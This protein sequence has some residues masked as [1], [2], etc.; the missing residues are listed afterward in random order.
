MLLRI[1]GL[2][3]LTK[4]NFR[5]SKFK[6]TFLIFTEASHCNSHIHKV[7]H[8][9]ENILAMKKPQSSIPSCKIINALQPTVNHN[10]I[11][12]LSLPITDETQKNIIHRQ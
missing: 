5:H 4:F 12:S 2:M 8:A 7:S 3:M 10:S 6:N 9:Q 1:P 11:Q